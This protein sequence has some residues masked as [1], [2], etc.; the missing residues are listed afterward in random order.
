ME[1]KL[2]RDVVGLAFTSSVPM[3]YAKPKAVKIF[4]TTARVHL[5]DSNG[6][7]HEMMDKMMA[8]F[9]EGVATGADS[10][11]GLFYCMYR[12]ARLMELSYGKRRK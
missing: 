1:K 4:D 6:V 2:S 7:S 9:A 11:R 10:M 12:E 8:V 5:Q 3:K